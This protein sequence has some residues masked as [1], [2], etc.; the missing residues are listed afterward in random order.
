MSW[1]NVAFSSKPSKFITGDDYEDG[2]KVK[3]MQVT[4]KS[5][6]TKFARIVRIILSDYT[7][8]QA[9]RQILAGMDVRYP[10][11]GKAPDV[12]VQS[13]PYRKGLSLLS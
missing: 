6:S 12:T 4:L 7:A 10:Q 2:F 8:S 11:E 5:A 9:T 3:V 13:S 1:I